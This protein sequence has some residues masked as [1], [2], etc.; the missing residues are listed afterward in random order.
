VDWLLWDGEFAAIVTVHQ[1]VLFG[2]CAYEPAVV[3]PLSLD[4]LELP[5]KVRPDKGEY[6]GT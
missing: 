1:R 2:G 6:E 5:V 4:E 3:Y